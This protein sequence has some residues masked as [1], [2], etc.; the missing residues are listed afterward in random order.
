M[1]KEKKFYKVYE[2][3]NCRKNLLLEDISGCCLHGYFCKDCSNNMMYEG[4]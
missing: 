3:F 4:V 1:E 2:C